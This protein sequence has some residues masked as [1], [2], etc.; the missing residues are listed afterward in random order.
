MASDR[1]RE[2]ELLAAAK[3]DFA[4][5]INNVIPEDWAKEEISFAPYWS[6]V[7]DEKEKVGNGFKATVLARDERGRDADGNPFIRYQLETALPLSCS[8]GDLNSRTMEVVSPGSKFTTSVYASLPLEMYYGCEV[9]VKVSGKRKLPPNE[10]SNGAHRDLFVFELFVSPDTRKML[11][12]ERKGAT[13]TDLKK[14]R[15][16]ARN[17]ALMAFSGEEGAPELNA[18]SL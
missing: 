13:N 9:M 6:P 4:E 14:L 7:W 12:E 18:A 5:G 17:R 15:A 3:T 10:H 2:D 11:D 1:E 8:R 16:E